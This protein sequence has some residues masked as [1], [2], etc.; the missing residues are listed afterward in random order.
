MARVSQAN[1]KD[2]DWYE[3]PLNY[4]IL[5]EQDT[6]VEAD[7]IEAV[8]QT[9]APRGAR[10]LLEPACGSG[11]LVH[12]LARRGYQLTGFDLNESMLAFAGE[13][14][15]TAGLKAQLLHA[16]LQDFRL[17]GKRDLA[18]CLLSSFRYLMDDK[19]AIEHLRRSAQSLVK[20][21]IYVL[22]LHLS[23]YDFQNMQHERWVAERE[24]MRVVCNLRSWPVERKQRREHLRSRITVTST[25]PSSEGQVLDR[26]ETEWDFRA[27]DE[28]QLRR[29]LNRVP[30]FEHIATY[31]FTYDLEAPRS[32]DDEHLDNVLI[33]RKR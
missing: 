14:L 19:S 31:D 26:L 7:F 12:E 1:F 6:Q 9:Y 8:L 30:E 20:G 15:Q 13:R 3:R 17:K 4:D 18:F 16:S 21:G 27:Y 33:L 10:R 32:L 25:K 29:L 22:G 5:L 11:R 23:E 24:E 28:K 2:L